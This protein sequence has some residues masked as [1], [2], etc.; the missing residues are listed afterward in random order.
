MEFRNNVPEDDLVELYQN[1][2]L[3]VL[4]SNEEGL[5]I[6]LLEAMASGLPVVSTDCGGTVTAVVPGETGYLTPVGDSEAL[7]TAMARVLGSV[8]LRKR[9]GRQGR[10]RAETHFSLEVAGTRFLAI[11]DW[12]LGCQRQ[13]PGDSAGVTEFP[14]ST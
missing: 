1:A 14:S 7:A 3:F 9:F 11:Y 4:S 10:E 8:Q 12:L 13:L 5:G 2:S 6:V